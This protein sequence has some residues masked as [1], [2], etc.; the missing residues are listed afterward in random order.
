MNCVKQTPCNS[1]APGD[2][3]TFFG[4]WIACRRG[5]DRPHL[6][7]RSDLRDLCHNFRISNT[8]TISDHPEGKARIYHTIRNLTDLPKFHRKKRNDRR[9]GNN[10]VELLTNTL[11]VNRTNGTLYND[12]SENS[13]DPCHT[14]AGGDS[15]TTDDVKTC[16]MTTFQ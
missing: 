11:G 4:N 3:K 15:R 16:V 5:P 6:H 12:R 1:N 13:I 9:V 7:D 8:Q 2:A 14:A 10:T